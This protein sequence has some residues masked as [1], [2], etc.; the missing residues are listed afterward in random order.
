[1]GEARVKDFSITGLQMMESTDGYAIRCNLLYKGRRLGEFLD[2]GD[3]GEYYFYPENGHTQAEVEA[4][5][6]GEDFPPIDNLF[7]DM[8]PLG[9]NIGI[10]VEHLIERRDIDERIAKAKREGR[11][12]II[13]TDMAKGE[14]YAITF[15]SHA[16][17]EAVAMYV[18]MHYGE[19]VSYVR[20]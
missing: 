8:P 14:R 19:A 4:M 5:L 10:L 20:Y 3:G 17:E 6:T 7:P 15:R 9:W 18:R 2:K 12:L 13:V 16:P 1:M 11:D